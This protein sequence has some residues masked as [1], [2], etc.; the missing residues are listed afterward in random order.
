[1]SELTFWPKFIL[2]VLAAWRITHLLTR[3]DGPADLI[4]RWR[5]RIGNGFFGKLM[6][7]FYCLSVWVA[8]PMAFSV[9]RKFVDWLI[10]W[11]AIS[12]AACLLERLTQEPV[13]IQPITKGEISDGMLRSEKSGEQQSALTGNEANRH[14][15]SA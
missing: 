6:D 15:A 3:E 13:V 11:W 7:C 12:G 5:L 10:T 8:A 9:S 2:A 1:M 14:A 4:V